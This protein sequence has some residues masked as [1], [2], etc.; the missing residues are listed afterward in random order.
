MAYEADSAAILLI[1]L[2][3]EADS[4]AVL[5]FLRWKKPIL[6]LVLPY[7]ADSAPI[8]RK[9]S[10]S[11]AHVGKCWLMFRNCSLTFP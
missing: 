7:A 6:L 4:A 2:Q 8:V 1:I 9:C 10:F 11:L 5:L 3:Y